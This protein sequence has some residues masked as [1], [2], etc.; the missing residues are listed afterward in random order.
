MFDFIIRNKITSITDTE[1]ASDKSN[2]SL[3]D[4]MDNAS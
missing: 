3:F 2:P 4:G 1:P